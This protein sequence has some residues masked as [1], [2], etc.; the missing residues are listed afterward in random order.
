MTDR[1]IIAMLE[2]SAAAAATFAAAG[3][4]QLRHAGYI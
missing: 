3:R 4:M 1:Y 2:R